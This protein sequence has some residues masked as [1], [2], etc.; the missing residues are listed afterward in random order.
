M[1]HYTTILLGY[2]SF[3]L[4]EY[5]ICAFRKMDCV[6]TPDTALNFFVHVSSARGNGTGETAI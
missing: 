6:P 5:M 1:L 2:A 4:Y 3:T